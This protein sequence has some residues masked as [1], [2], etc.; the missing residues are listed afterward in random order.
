M[1]RL[2]GTAWRRLASS[3]TTLTRVSDIFEEAI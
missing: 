2:T 3:M 1:M